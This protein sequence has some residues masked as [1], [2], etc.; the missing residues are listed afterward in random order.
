MEAAQFFPQYNSQRVKI[1]YGPFTTASRDVDNGMANFVQMN[2]TKPCTDC[3]IT[4]MQAGL[5]Y[6]GGGIA[7]A[8]THLWL[9]HTVIFNLDK[10]NP[11]C[12]FRG[13][14]EKIFASGN[15]RTPIDI[16]SSG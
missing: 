14:V 12:P 15:E 8:N 11:V 3:T 9:H 16:S 13:H 7:D 5:E 6:E 2:V 4:F 10:L 1:R